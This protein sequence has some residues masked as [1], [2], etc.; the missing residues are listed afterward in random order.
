MYVNQLIIHFYLGPNLKL[1]NAKNFDPGIHHCLS[2]A[3]F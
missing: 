1:E 3:A 2:L